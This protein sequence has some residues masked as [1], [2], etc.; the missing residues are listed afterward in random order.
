MV[1]EPADTIFRTVITPTISITNQQGETFN[2]TI[3]WKNIKLVSK[4]P[5]QKYIQAKKMLSPITNLFNV[6]RGLY[7]FFLILFSVALLV[8][9]FVEIRKQHY[10]VIAQTVFMI[11]LLVW[12]VYI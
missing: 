12:L 8:N 11:A 10:Y 5:L 6:S 7:L 4:T 9:I 2:D 1:N 3:E